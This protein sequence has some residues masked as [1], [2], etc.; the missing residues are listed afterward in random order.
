MSTTIFSHPWSEAWFLFD[1]SI[2]HVSLCKT[3]QIKNYIWNELILMNF[4]SNG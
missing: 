1:F 2:E 3:T 4:T